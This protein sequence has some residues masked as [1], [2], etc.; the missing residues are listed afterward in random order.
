[1]ANLNKVFL[2]GNLTRDPELR[3]TG[4]GNT[5]VNFS[6]ATNRK[7]RDKEGE[8]QTETAYVDC[9]AWGR[10]AETINKYVHKGS[11]LYVEGRLRLEST[12]SEAGS[13]EHR[14]WRRVGLV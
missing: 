10:D 14:R 11:P 5:V 12:H 9:A 3:Q 4:G 2:M 13:T 8:M 1:M 6:L 7:W